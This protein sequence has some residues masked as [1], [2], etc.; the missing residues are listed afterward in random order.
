[1]YFED[2]FPLYLKVGFSGRG[3]KS[4]LGWTE[5]FMIGN[6]ND[7]GQRG[8]NLSCLPSRREQERGF[9]RM[10]RSFFDLKNFILNLDQAFIHGKNSLAFRAFDLYLSCGSTTQ[11][12]NGQHH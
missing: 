5:G 7:E 8:E 1:L 10:K 11:R 6:W 3:I 4:V 2:L 9:Q 12:E